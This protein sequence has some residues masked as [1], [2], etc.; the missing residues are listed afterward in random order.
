MIDPVSKRCVGVIAKDG[1]RYEADR[2]VMATGAWS[3]SLIDL[4]GQCVSKVCSAS[5]AMHKGD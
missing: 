3:P 2:I 4:K 1:S 5:S